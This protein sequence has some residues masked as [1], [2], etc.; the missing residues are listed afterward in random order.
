MEGL[1]AQ[2]GRVPAKAVCRIPSI[3]NFWARIAMPSG[4][5]AVMFVPTAGLDTHAKI[6][7]DVFLRLTAMDVCCGPPIEA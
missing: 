7:I 1:A 6:A 4:I 2:P 3:E 5:L